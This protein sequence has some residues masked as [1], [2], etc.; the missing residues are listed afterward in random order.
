MAAGDVNGDGA[1]AVAEQGPTT[2]IVLVEKRSGGMVRISLGYGEIDGDELVEMIISKRPCG[3]PA[4]GP[5]NVFKVALDEDMSSGSSVHDIHVNSG[6][7]E[8]HS[9]DPVQERVNVR[10]P[11]LQSGSPG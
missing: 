3:Q 11:G 7:P 6:Q 9:I 5:T 4:T 2:A 1:V 10:I 8:R